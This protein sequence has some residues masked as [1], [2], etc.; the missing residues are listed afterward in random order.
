M[1]F[2]KE[3]ES[4]FIPRYKIDLS[5]LPRVGPCSML[6]WRL[7]VTL[8]LAVTRCTLAM[9]RRHLLGALAD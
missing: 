7:A 9:R 2:Q 8:L 4:A 3:D 1:G 5:L 6:D